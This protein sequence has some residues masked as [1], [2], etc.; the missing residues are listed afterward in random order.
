MIYS[1]I[2]DHERFM[3]LFKDRDFNE[4]YK[5]I[6][7]TLCGGQ[8]SSRAETILTLELVSK[9]IYNGQ[10][11]IDKTFGGMYRIGMKKLVLAQNEL[12]TASDIPHVGKDTH[13]IRL[14]NEFKPIEVKT[15]ADLTIFQEFVAYTMDAKV[16]WWM[17]EVLG[18]MGQLLN[19]TTR[20]K[21]IALSI[22]RLLVTECPGK[23]DNV[24]DNLLKTKGWSRLQ[25]GLPP[26][27][28]LNMPKRKNDELCRHHRS[29]TKT[30]R[31]L[32]NDFET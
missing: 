7:H 10:L 9:Y 18:T 20:Q 12:K 4:V 30:C 23:Y 17:N 29:R 8:Y 13:V 2:P 28:P 25:Q 19:G 5:L 6:S 26:N 14:I 22:Y 21:D 3:L 16:A 31:Y 24:V 27:S 11:P 32:P 1:R 15:D